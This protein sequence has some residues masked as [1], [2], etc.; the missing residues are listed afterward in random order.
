MKLGNSDNNTLR[1]L[2]SS[3]KGMK[4]YVVI[5]VVLNAVSA[6]INIFSALLLAGIVDS[7]VAKDWDS[8]RFYCTLEITKVI[9]QTL[10]AVLR[11]YLEEHTR[12]SLEN[13]LKQRLFRN[14]LIGDYAAVTAV[15]SGEWMTRLTSDAAVVAN[16]MTGIL[17]GLV[18][19]VVRLALSLCL[20]VSIAPLFGSGLILGG[21]IVILFTWGLRRAMKNLHKKVQESDSRLRVFLT[22]RLGSMMI[23]R[24]F[25][26]EDVAVKQ[27]VEY[28]NAHKSTRMK[29][30]HITN[31]FHSGFSFLV[32]CVYVGGAIFCGYGIL[33]GTMSYGSFTA[34]LQLV[35]KV[36][37]PI[38]NISGFFPQYSAMLASA[39]RLMEAE[40]HQP[41]RKQPAV[42]DMQEYYHNTFRAIGLRN[43][44]FS[45]LAV[46]DKEGN[47]ESRPTVLKG[48]NMEI[49]KGEYVAFCGPSGCGKSTVL[50]L[51]MSLYN[52]DEGQRY[53]LDSEGER[54]MD[55]AWRGLYAYVPQ[56]NQLMSGTIRDVI[57]F[58]DPQERLQHEKIR[59]ALEI[60]CAD[61][62]VSELPEGLDTSL[63]ERGAG[64]SEG[65]M[66]R[67]AIARAIFS[68]RPILLLDE[69]TSA[70]DEQ[71]E[72]KVLDNLRS[73]TD[74][75][76][77][78][79]THRPAA[80]EITD[81]I[82]TFKPNEE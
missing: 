1:W 23:L 41:E 57:T 58:A 78:I 31:L 19:M 2:Y 10:L 62:F 13:N 29:K 5:L 54:P 77:I 22:E 43:A 36:Q 20:V 46:G 11:H 42:E 76:V 53:L 38:G 33:N 70:L 64:L 47:K 18:G 27:G 79:V 61:Q 66:Q 24:A 55:A 17:P 80:L 30:N 32:N 16:G 51:L 67:I 48:L 81:K 63:G 75:T 35:A 71:T 82:I 3:A 26:Q 73:M 4:R 40:A 44:G 68:D 9:V 74:K 34:M 69:A 7:A 72:A 28:M 21:G 60:A 45:Y 6:A 56:G 49:A 8:F 65:Q 59:R 50:K 12:S 15:H 14:I 37:A 39:E 52:L 25:E